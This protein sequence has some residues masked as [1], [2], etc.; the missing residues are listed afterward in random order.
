MEATFVYGSPYIF[1]RLQPATDSDL[2]RRNP[3]Q[4]GIWHEGKKFW[5]LDQSPAEEITSVSCGNHLTTPK[6]RW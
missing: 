3:G 4:R 5:R 2:A 6:A 1:L